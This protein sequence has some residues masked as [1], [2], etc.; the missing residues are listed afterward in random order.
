MNKK[1]VE[2]FAEMYFEKTIELLGCSKYYKHTPYLVVEN[3][4]QSIGIDNEWKG[5]F[6]REENEIIIY[7]KNITDMEDLARTVVHE[8]AHYLQS[9]NWMQRYYN[10]GY[11]YNTH[12]YEVEAFLVEEQNWRKIC[13]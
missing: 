6:V 13:K 11:T 4:P 9:A 2:R 3:S 1:E 7:S 5:E 10:M 8:Y 12:P